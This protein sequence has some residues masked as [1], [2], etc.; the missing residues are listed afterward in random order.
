MPKQIING[1]FLNQRITGV[2]RYAIGIANHLKRADI[3]RPSSQRFI[4]QVIWEQ[5]TLPN[6][7]KKKGSPLLL[8]FCNTAPIHY[9]NQIVTIHDL[10]VFEN[11]KW[12]SQSFAAYYKF[13][14]PRIARNAKH[15][16]TVSEFSKNEIQKHLRVSQDKISVIPP[17][18][19]DDLVTK[20]AMKPAG[21]HSKFILMVGSHDPRKNFGFAIEHAHHIINAMDLKLVHV[22]RQSHVFSSS[23]KNTNASTIQLTDTTDQ[24]L[25]WLYENAEALIQPSIYEGFSLVP[26]EAR[27]SGCPALVSDIPVHREVLGD[28]VKYFQLHNP[29]SFK[30][31]LEN[32]LSV[33]K[34]LTKAKWNYD[35]KA[36]AEKW[37]DL[38]ARFE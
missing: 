33:K 16:V 20:P 29:E 26:M 9:R 12:F 21:I 7:L 36:S 11:P 13:L 25:K 32:I 3:S 8:N 4:S 5:T 17:G 34:P 22:G 2:Q 35:F 1:R 19:D 38:I 28:D 37:K 23:E 18:I 24:E 10:A 14:L 6:Q 15:I 31:S 27:S 30:S